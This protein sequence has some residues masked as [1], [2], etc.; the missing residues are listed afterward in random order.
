ELGPGGEER[1]ARAEPAQ[2][3]VCGHFV[4]PRRGFDDRAPVVGRE[5]R[6]GHHRHLAGT[7]R[8]AAATALAA[9]GLGSASAAAPLRRAEGAALGRGHRRPRN[10]IAADRSIPSAARPARPSL[11]GRVFV[12]TCGSGGNPYTSGSSSRR[13]TDPMPPTPSESFAPYS[14]A[15]VMPWSC[16]SA[17][18]SF[19]VSTISCRSPNLIDV[20]AQVWAHAGGCPSVSRS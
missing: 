12:H 17:T 16:S 5:L 13:K 2:E 4:L 8:A 10:A 9:A 7:V 15:S 3:Q 19:A 1:R 14:R 11:R 20:V 6:L 18:R